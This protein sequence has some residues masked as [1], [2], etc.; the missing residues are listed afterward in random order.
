[1]QIYL[2]RRLSDRQ[3]SQNRNSQQAFAAIEGDA[4]PRNQK[5]RS[6]I[7]N[8]STDSLYLVR[9]NVKREETKT[10]IPQKRNLNNQKLKG[11][12]KNPIVN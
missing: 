8:L 4:K 7:P 6:S 9:A 3:H 12:H 2:E 5:D 11:K 10:G 1:M